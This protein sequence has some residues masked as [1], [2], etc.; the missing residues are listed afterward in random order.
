[1]AFPERFL[2]ELLARSD[3]ADIA[4]GYV[5]LTKRS[6]TSLFGLCPFHSE[7]TPS[8]SVSQDKQIYHCFGCGK[9]GGAI[10]FIMEIENLSFPDA[11]RFLAK[12]AGLTI[13]EE[14]GES[15]S[16][17]RRTRMLE[18]NRD[19]ARFFYELLKKPEGKTAVDYISRR[20]ISA[21]M[22][23][24]F[25]LGFA[26]D[27]WNALTDAMT[28]LG[29]SV[30]ELLDTGL[31]KRAQG[32]KGVYDTFRG[33]IMFPVI[34]VRGS[35]IGFSGRIISSGEPKYLNSSDSIVFSKSRN[36]FALNFAKKTKEGMLILVEGNIDVI[37]LHQAGFDSAVASLGTAL[38]PEQ[39]RLMARYTKNVVI[40]YDSDSAGEKAAKRAIDILEKTGLGVKVL[41]MDGAKDPDEFIRARGPDAFRILLERSEN[42]IEYRLLSAKAK[43][44]FDTDEGRLGVLTEATELLSG[45]KSAVEREIYGIR[46]AEY[47]NVSADALANEVK[48]A[49]RKRVVDENKKRERAVMR[50]AQTMQPKD[51]D[52]R[53]P[54]VRSAA[55]EEGVIRLLLLDQA[56]ISQTDGIEESNFTSEFLGKVYRMLSEKYEKGQ[57][58]SLPILMAELEPAEASR[59]TEILQKP[60]SLS[61]AAEAMRDY[62]EKIRTEELKRTAKDDLLEVTRKY[63]EKKGMEDKRYGK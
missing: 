14:G 24:K 13:P 1:M 51:R 4:S 46:A 15:V 61:N 58:V 41:R 36:L 27:S 17:G 34:D 60:E 42:H 10:N 44:D 22:L 26:P 40:A 62:I 12:R 9:G 3:I 28:G 16:S 20:G 18:L 29:Y 38:S 8:F 31:V 54:N 32:G 57:N 49:I 23:K 39:A 50:P 47:A 7:K 56:L 63:R 30:S 53:Y 35:I 43:Y 45:L 37:S 52:L 59:L 5:Q 6:G 33:R 21:A 19:A 25:G 2:D 48:K 55:A 11:V